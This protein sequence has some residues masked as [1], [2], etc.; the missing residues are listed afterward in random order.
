[1]ARIALI[2]QGSYSFDPRVRRE[3]DALLDA[4][5]EVDVICLRGPDEPVR[6]RQGRLRVLRLPMP[7]KP[8]GAVSYFVYYGVFMAVAAALVTL[9]HLV[10][11]YR[12]VQVNTLPD[13]LVFAA[14]M[15]R[16]LGARVL[17]DLHECMPEFAATKFGK[18][19]T[20]PLVRAVAGAEQASIRFSD[21]AITCTEQM[22]EAFVAR[23]ADRSG[24]GVIHNTADESVWD[25]IAYPPR[26]REPGRFRLICHGSIEPRYGLDTAIR[27]VA[28]LQDEIPELELKIFGEGSELER[29]RALARELGVAERVW[30]SGRMVPM[31]ELLAAVAEAD[32]GIVAMTRDEFRDLTHCNK[33]YDLI[34]MRRPVLSSW[35]RS[36]A[37]Y[38]SEDALL[39]FESEN[40]HDLAR[41]IRDLHDDPELGNRAAARAAEEIE[42]YRWPV[43]R[44]LYQGFIADLAA[45]R[46]PSA[47]E[48]APPEAQLERGLQ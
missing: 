44:A 19:M 38:F 46:R 2:R 26:P 29:L 47:L 17:L 43:Q 34:A 31:P 25:P 12:V 32:A 20:H 27:A 14:L 3:V 15:P 45:R 1:M 37:E 11:R 21:F 48:A 36:V 35:T 8:T 24:I 30:F 4:G 10:R 28:L 42:P 40:E 6:Q 5:H 23:G 33:M 16:L 13:P 18:P 39:F 41:R 9:L 7:R 22:R